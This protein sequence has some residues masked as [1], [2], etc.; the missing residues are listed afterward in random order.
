[1][2]FYNNCF[3]YDDYLIDINDNGA[4][5]L[6]DTE[7]YNSHILK[8]HIYGKINQFEKHLRYKYLFQVVPIAILV[9]KSYFLHMVIT[10]FF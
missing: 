2:N 7:N 6:G 8:T 10:E 4:Y 5:S 1:M 9:L 3:E